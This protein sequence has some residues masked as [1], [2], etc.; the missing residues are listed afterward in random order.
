MVRPFLGRLTAPILISA[1]CA[2]NQSLFDEDVE[3]DGP[4]AT[5]DG[6][7]DAAD[8]A[9]GADGADDAG[10]GADD[11]ADDGVNPGCPEP[12]QGDPVVDFSLEQGGSNGRWFYIVDRGEANG[13]GFDP[14]IAGSFDG[15]EAWVVADDVGPAI[16]SCAGNAPPAVCDGAGESL[17]FIPGPEGG[18]SPALAFQAPTN[19]TFRLAGE[20]VLPQGFEE[21]VA[22]QFLVSRN[23]R[24][25]LSLRSAFLTSASAEPLSVDVE[26]LQEDRI[27]LTLPFA[28]AADGAPIA[29]DFAVTLL[30]GEEDV[31]PG[32][33]MFAAR[34]DA[35]EPFTERCGGATLDNL[36]DGEGPAGTTVEGPSVEDQFGSAR[37]FGEAQYMRSLGAPMDYSGDFTVQFW[38][39]FAEPQPS[40]DTVAF[41]DAVDEALGGVVFLIR[42]TEA[43]LLDACFLW[44]EGVDPPP[45]I[46][47]SDCI[48]G[49]PPADK[50]WH[51]FRLSRSAGDGAISLCIDGELQGSNTRPSAF[52]MSSDTA[53]F[54]GKGVFSTFAL[55]GGS[56]DDV[57]I[58]RRAL[59]CSA[60]P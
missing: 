50:N 51:F 32:R 30:G 38:A 47:P 42:D 21:G 25:D 9:D 17:V 1:L 26:A 22:R 56:V 19:G 57:R 16:V 8:G 45:K 6:A 46:P 33:C 54:L 37:V 2:C 7:D 4:G 11:G 55:F 52:D 53:P 41:T 60:A 58:I 15:A 12:C 24:H 3:D 44:D 48:R 34:F 10:D 13:A 36:N 20:F 18:A 29:F 35:D 28:D 23:A 43:T 59:P 49:E 39:N 5:D 14:L 27:L 31:F 40:F